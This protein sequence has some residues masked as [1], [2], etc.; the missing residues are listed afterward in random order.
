MKNKQATTRNVGVIFPDLSGLRVGLTDMGGQRKDGKRHPR[1][2]TD[3]EYDFFEKTGAIRNV[4]MLAEVPAEVEIIR[5]IHVCGPNGFIRHTVGANLA[6]MP[7][8]IDGFLADGTLQV[9][10]I[11]C[12]WSPKTTMKVAQRGYYLRHDESWGKGLTKGERQQVRAAV[13][14]DPAAYGVSPYVGFPDF[15]RLGQAMQEAED[16]EKERKHAEF[17]KAGE[18]KITREGKPAVN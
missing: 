16:A 12:S 1:N 4:R 15:S 9:L 13:P 14:F 7:E 10:Q 6:T 18:V 5:D 11:F 17:A 8:R 3:R 2:L